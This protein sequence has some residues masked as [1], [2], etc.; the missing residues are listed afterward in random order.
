MNRNKLQEYDERYKDYN[1]TETEYN[2]ILEAK[3]NPDA[4]EYRE[5][6]DFFDTLKHFANSG[7]RYYSFEHDNE[8]TQY[9]TPEL[10]IRHLL[11]YP[12]DDGY[13]EYLKSRKEG[14]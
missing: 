6:R 9:W 14:D 5:L 4:K 2:K 8:N 11:M 7:A 1:Q 13:I 10:C 3:E 12:S